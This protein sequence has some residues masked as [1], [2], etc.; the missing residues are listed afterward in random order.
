MALN[1]KLFI[2]RD[3]GYRG[4]WCGIDPW[5]VAMTL[6]RNNSLYVEYYDRNLIQKECGQLMILVILKMR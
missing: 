2:D 4:G 5:K 3:F 1:E 6:K